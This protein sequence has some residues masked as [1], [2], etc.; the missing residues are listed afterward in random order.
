MNTIQEVFT[1][2]GDWKKFQEN[3]SGFN[4]EL[5]YTEYMFDSEDPE[6]GVL[7][8]YVGGKV[9]GNLCVDLDT[10][11]KINHIPNWRQDLVN[12]FSNETGLNVR[13]LKVW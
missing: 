7:T 1:P 6:I 13:K 10:I 5:G 3:Q 9:N 12:H 2:R 8:Y 4:N 11:K